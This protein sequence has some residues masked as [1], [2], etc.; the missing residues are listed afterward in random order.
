MANQK[1]LVGKE[2]TLD[3]FNSSGS[4]KDPTDLPKE[5]KEGG[6]ERPRA[7]AVKLYDIEDDSYFI[8]LSQKYGGFQEENAVK[9]GCLEEG[10]WINA[11]CLKKHDE[12]L[13]RIANSQTKIEEKKPSIPLSVSDVIKEI[14]ADSKSVPDEIKTKKELSREGSSIMTNENLV[15][16]GVR[17]GSRKIVN[18][19]TALLLKILEADL[20]RD[21]NW[22][23][24]DLLKKANKKQI[25]ELANT[26]KRILR[27][28][29]GKAMINIFASWL[30]TQGSGKL[31]K[32]LPGAV[33]MT[34][35]LLA[36]E[37]R[38]EAAA[39]GIEVVVD[40]TLELVSPGLAKILADPT[41][42]SL[43]DIG[44][45]VLTELEKKN[46]AIPDE[47][48]PKEVVEQNTAAKTN[49]SLN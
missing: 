23:E 1:D 34:A 17:A 21:N 16:G 7:F 10:T 26:T 11:S 39:L 5:W 2:I 40:K 29:L 49:A 47:L 18:A 28:D 9:L 36:E 12:I 44:S 20:V 8:L 45:Q 27:T 41:N 15:A 4:G 14:K 24:K 6:S 38:T 22:S 37:M 13:K 42:V 31:Q 32:Y 46:L 43:M 30:M 33:G 48:L 19:L 25:I 35:D 3:D